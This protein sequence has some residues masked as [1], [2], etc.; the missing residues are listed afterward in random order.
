[1]HPLNTVHTLVCRV[2]LKIRHLKYSRFIAIRYLKH[3]F[4]LLFNH[5]DMPFTWKTKIIIPPPKSSRPD[6][7]GLRLILSPALEVFQRP[8][9][10]LKPFFFFIQHIM[11]YVPTETTPPQ[12]SLYFTKSQRIQQGRLNFRIVSVRVN[13]NIFTS[14][15][16]ESPYS[17][18]LK[19][20]LVAV[21]LPFPVG[22]IL[23]R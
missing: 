1:M 9:I 19:H 15:L 3:L 6:G 17:K 14:M 10:L 2:I 8:L 20:R 23:Y 13:H 16:I 22:Y 4:N 21:C 18:N 12:F 5:S 11:A 7:F